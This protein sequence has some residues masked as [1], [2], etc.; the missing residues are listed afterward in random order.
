MNVMRRLA[1]SCVCLLALSLHA[2][3]VRQQV[4]ASKGV[5]YRCTLA[6]GSIR[7]TTLANSGCVALFSYVAKAAVS[8]RPTPQSTQQKVQQTQAAHDDRLIESGSYV[9]KAGDTVHRPAHTESGL[10]PTGATA[11]CRDGSYSFSQSRRGTC[12]YHGGVLRW[13]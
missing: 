1:M 9:N 7:Y 11:Q 2:Q 4:P 8:Q 3:D 5:V 13:L 12:S 10:P 6:D